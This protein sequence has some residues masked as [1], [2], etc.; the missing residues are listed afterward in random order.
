MT[1]EDRIYGLIAQAED[2]QPTLAT[3]V[4]NMA[5][6]V[7]LLPQPVAP[8]ISRLI[9]LCFRASTFLFS[10]VTFLLRKSFFLFTVSR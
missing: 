7:E 5:L 10:E 3:S 2:I 1:P 9:F 4:S 8:V 6:M